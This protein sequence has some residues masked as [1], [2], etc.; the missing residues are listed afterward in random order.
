MNA[1]AAFCFMN[2]T[3]S[4]EGGQARIIAL[5]LTDALAQPQGG[6]GGRQ[7]DRVNVSKI[8]VEALARE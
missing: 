4:R 1:R 5:C 6:I 8:I 7:K 2:E 3:K